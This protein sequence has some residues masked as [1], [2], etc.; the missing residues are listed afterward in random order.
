MS[1]LLI[2]K[3]NLPSAFIDCIHEFVKF[4]LIESTQDCGI[5]QISYDDFS[6]SGLFFKK[7][8]V[9]E[10]TSNPYGQESSV[11]YEYYIYQ[12]FKLINVN[13]K[14]YL[15]LITPRKS[16]KDFYKF[17]HTAFGFNFSIE[18]TDIDLDKVCSK[19]DG[20]IGFKVTK[21]KFSGVAINNSNAVVELA[22]YANA[23]TD[24]RAKFGTTYKKL[25]R[26]K[27]SFFNNESLHEVEISNTGS[28]NINHDLVDDNLEQLVTL[29][30]N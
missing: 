26:V 8:S 11:A 22:S 25:S 30:F 20:N 7:V 27:V 14:S 2:L 5:H 3:V 13:D 18:H 4:S 21:A 1:K 10:T 12:E 23:L 17:I 16:L 9:N 29:I 19:L 28:I 24:F 15:L 6:L